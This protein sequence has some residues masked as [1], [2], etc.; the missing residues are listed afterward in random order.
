LQLDNGLRFDRFEVVETDARGTV[1]VLRS[2]GGVI[3][4]GTGAGTST[5][6][7]QQLTTDANDPHFTYRLADPITGPAGTELVDATTLA[8]QT[9][10]VSLGA[11]GGKIANAAADATQI[12]GER[13]LGHVEGAGAGT[14]VTT[15]GNLEV[16]GTNIGDVTPLSVDGAG[17]T[18]NLELDAAVDVAANV[19]AQIERV[20]LVQ[21]SAAGDV[22]LTLPGVGGVATIDGSVIDTGASQIEQSQVVQIRTNGTEF[23]YHLA[24]NSASSDSTTSGEPLLRVPT[25]SVTAV[26]PRPGGRASS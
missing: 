25:G 5:H 18:Q 4:H 6:T 15:A 2:T 13:L 7:I 10:A 20:D 22:A 8:V 17:G 1:D 19:G 26:H 21:R 9:G 16:F 11:S 14:H 24:D 12:E 3:A 23:F